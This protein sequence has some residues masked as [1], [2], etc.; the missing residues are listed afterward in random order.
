M[1]L[2]IRKSIALLLTSAAIATGSIALTTNK[3]EAYTQNQEDYLYGV[4]SALRAIGL[5]WDATVLL[6][7]SDMQQ[8]AL[9]TGY[10][11]CDTMDLGATPEDMF[12]YSIN[13]GAT[14]QVSGH[15]LAM[16]TSAALTLCPEHSWKVTGETQEATYY[17]PSGSQASSCVSTLRSDTNIRSGP[18]ATSSV[19][20]NESTLL[21]SAIEIH[22]TEQGRDGS[23][24]SWIGFNGSDG[25]TAGW[26]RSDFINRATC[27]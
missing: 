2:N 7:D 9:N 26:V 24:W 21:N 6:S 11:A 18:S 23:Y 25:R 16:A 3:A 10:T 8:T 22:S 5:N 15:V 14:S 4:A 1:K 19:I 12:R 13:N 20:G 27:D 17:A